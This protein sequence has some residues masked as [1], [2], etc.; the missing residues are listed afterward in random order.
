M[1]GVLMEKVEWTLS[2]D[3]E[4][5]REYKIKWLV[6]STSTA[7]GPLTIANT[8]GLPAVGSTWSFGNDLDSW[9]FCWPQ[10]RIAPVLDAEVSEYWT[11]E[12]MF[13]T[14]P[15]QRCQDTDIEN[16]LNEPDKISGGFTKYT[17]EATHDQSGDAILTSSLEQI[18]G[19]VVERDANRPTVTIGKNLLT[20]PLSTFAP[21]IDTVNDAGLWGLP[22]RCVK[23]SNVSWQRNLYGTCTFYYT[24]NYEFDVRYDTFDRT[25]LDEGTRVLAPGGDATDPDDFIVY[26]DKNGENTRVILD[27]SGEAWDGTGTPGEIGPVE[28]YAESNFLTLGIPTSL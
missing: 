22:A 27:G 19:S 15:L 12:Q 7:D 14:R 3:K 8:A 24:V 9:A 23:L 10:W 28:F 5:H 2:R 25:L 4:G 13:T 16:P 1:A 20:L 21:M 26:K 17:V 11:V 6:R 18:R